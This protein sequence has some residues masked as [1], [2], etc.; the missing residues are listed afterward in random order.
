M[1]GEVVEDNENVLTLAHEILADRAGGERGQVLLPR[2]RLRVCG[3]DHCA[4][5]CVVPAQD[6]HDFGYA[7][8]SAGRW[9]H[10]CTRD[11]YG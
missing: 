7:S 10:K 5:Q 8:L 11:R 2:R 9:P 3:H 6:F 4:G 1:L